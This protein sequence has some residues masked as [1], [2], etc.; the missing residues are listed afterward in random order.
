[1]FDHMPEPADLPVLQTD[2][3]DSLL[4][5]NFNEEIHVTPTNATPSRDGPF[6]NASP[7]P[8]RAKKKRGSQDRPTK[9]GRW[10]KEE[11]ERFLEGFRS[12]GRD[13]KGIASVVKT[14]SAVQIRTH[15][16][17]FFQKATKSGVKTISSSDSQQSEDIFRKRKSESALTG[18]TQQ[19]P[20]KRALSLPRIQTPP[21]RP[22]ESE[23]ASYSTMVMR[24]EV[25]ISQPNLLV[26]P[27]H[28]SAEEDG[29]QPVEIVVPEAEDLNPPPA[30][31]TLPSSLPLSFH[32]EMTS[33][34]YQHPHQL[35]SVAPR[36]DVIYDSPYPGN[37]AQPFHHANDFTISPASHIQPYWPA[38]RHP[39]PAQAPPQHLHPHSLAH[40]PSHARPA[41][42][43]ELETL[44]F[45]DELFMPA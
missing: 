17:K 32:S 24:E 36:D 30:P 41:S 21:L 38:P 35:Y 19:Y 40:P 45:D 28:T 10:D 37:A 13:W 34:H 8:T 42:D 33:H 2:G 6:G 3:S 11:H 44:E 14:R 15:A 43:F 1:M 31:H 22:N 9:T 39:N 5:W 23:T 18:I 12:F 16:Q 25:L 26:P 20:N 27:A 29:L 4:D 7:L